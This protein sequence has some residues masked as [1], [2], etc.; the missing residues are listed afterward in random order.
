MAVQT[1][2]SEL[3]SA[4]QLGANAILNQWDDL[5]DNYG[6]SF[7]SGDSKLQQHHVLKF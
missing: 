7:T 3:G 1:D 5:A 6:D 2:L 4:L